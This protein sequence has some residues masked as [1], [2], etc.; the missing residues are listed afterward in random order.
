MDASLSQ[1]LTNPTAYVVCA[2]FGLI[3]VIVN[4][5]NKM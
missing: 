1:A 2:L 3:L 4:S 5:K